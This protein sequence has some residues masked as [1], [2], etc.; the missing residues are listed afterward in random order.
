MIVKIIGKDK[1]GRSRA[2]ADV[3]G[4]MVHNCTVEELRDILN[5]FEILS[6]HFSLKISVNSAN[7]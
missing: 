5:A 3:H 4:C 1:T 2:I 6:R 7:D